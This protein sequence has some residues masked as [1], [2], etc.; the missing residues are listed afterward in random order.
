MLLFLPSHPC[1]CYRQWV[2]CVQ[3]LLSIVNW[4]TISKDRDLK[5]LHHRVNNL[6]VQHTKT[7][8]VIDLLNKYYLNF[9]TK[10]DSH[11]LTR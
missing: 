3:A 8:L 6:P 10:Q 2:G 4:P 5:V 1:R 11:L 7:V 9:Q